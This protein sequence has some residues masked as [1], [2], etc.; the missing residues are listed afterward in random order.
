MTHPNEHGIDV[1]PRVVR[2][3]DRGPGLSIDIL[4][5]GGSE[6]AESQAKEQAMPPFIFTI[7]GR[8]KVSE[9]EYRDWQRG[10]SARIAADV[11]KRREDA[12]ADGDAQKPPV[13]VMPRHLWL[14]ARALDLG[15]A[16]YE[17]TKA[18]RLPDA[19]K[20]MRTW[21][22]ELDDLLLQIHEEAREEEGALL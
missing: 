19:A 7:P 15:R 6:P 21:S 18:G 17:Y 4:L 9:E 11:H 2:E 10:V 5:A 16:L 8:G 22:R 3:R 12:R 20:L 13:G 1:F 14:E